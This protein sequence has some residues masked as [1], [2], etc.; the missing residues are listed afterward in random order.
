[1]IY[2]GDAGGPNDGRNI[3]TADLDRDAGKPPPDR[4]EIDV[5]S[6]DDAEG[7]RDER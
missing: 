7:D 6:A 3:T 2:A 5:Y 4:L 1:M